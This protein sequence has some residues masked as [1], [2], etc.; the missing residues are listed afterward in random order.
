MG[1]DSCASPV[2]IGVSRLKIGGAAL[3]EKQV[4]DVFIRRSCTRDP[5]A[6][7]GISV[8]SF[9]T[10]SVESKPPYQQVP[11]IYPL[12]PSSVRQKADRTPTLSSMTDISSLY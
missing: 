12:W 8:K 9:P 3:A 2:L 10:A 6:K 4:P 7:A 5:H 11:D 1:Y